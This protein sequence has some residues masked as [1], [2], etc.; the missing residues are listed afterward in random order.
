MP[1]PSVALLGGLLTPVLPLHAQRVG[2]ASVPGPGAEIVFLDVG[3][4]DA[5]L[6]RSDTF[7]VLIDAGR[8][9]SILYVLDSLGVDHIN[10]LIATHN[11]I[12]HIGGMDAVIDSLP[13]E[14]F[15]DNGCEDDSEAEAYVMR[16]LDY[17]HLAAREPGP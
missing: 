8:A 9:T 11:H 13:V 12:D 7:N 1:K 4:G 2:R 14:L 3:Q 10:L 6:I 5:I 16:S 17:A 15:V